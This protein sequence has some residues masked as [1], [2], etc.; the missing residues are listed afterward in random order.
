MPK[1][2][3]RQINKNV[4]TP[5]TLDKKTNIGIMTNTQQKCHLLCSVCEGKL[6]RKEDY[7]SAFSHYGATPLLDNYRQNEKSEN[8]SVAILPS[9]FDK[10]QL[11]Y[12]ALSVFWRYSINHRFKSI[13]LGPYAEKIRLFLKEEDEKSLE[14]IYIVFNLVD[15]RGKESTSSISVLPL[16][17]TKKPFGYHQFLCL[18]LKFSLI[19]GNNTPPSAAKLCLIRSN[20]NEVQITPWEKDNLVKESTGLVYSVTPKGKLSKNSS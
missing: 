13:E 20:S 14:G 5:I 1:W 10:K 6:S 8:N 19:V 16:T 9:G 18:G 4:S 7:V 15:S 12:F 17:Y 2:V 11:G 3:Y